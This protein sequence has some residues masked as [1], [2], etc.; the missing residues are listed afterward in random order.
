MCPTPTS[1]CN[2]G[3]HWFMPGQASLQCIGAIGD[4]FLR[5][6]KG[7]FNTFA[8]CTYKLKP[9]YKALL[10][11]KEGPFPPGNQR[12]HRY[13]RPRALGT[14][15]IH[16]HFHQLSLHFSDRS[17]SCCPVSAQTGVDDWE[18]TFEQAF[19]HS[20]HGNIVSKSKS[21]PIVTTPAPQPSAY[22]RMTEQIGHDEK[23]KPKE[24][25]WQPCCG[26]TNHQQRG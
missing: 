24:F 17:V 3:K 18:Q 8:F 1:K 25:C 2:T 22:D 13:P 19:I 23:R 5:T 20:L 16:F 21:K 26:E 7:W 9:K 4:R 6:K 11:N 12:A 14:Y 10:G 15:I